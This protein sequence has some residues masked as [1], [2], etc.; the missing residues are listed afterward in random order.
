MKVGVAK[1]SAPGETRVAVV[2]DTARRLVGDGV[3]VLVERG[4]G[5]TAT[6][7]DAAYEQAG[8]A[9]C[10]TSSTPRRTSPAGAQ[11]VPDEVGAE[12]GQVLL[13][14]AAGRR[15]V[16][17]LAAERGAAL[18]DSIRR[19]TRAKPMDALVPEHG[20]RLHGGRPRGVPGSS[21]GCS[22]PRGHDPA[23]SPVLAPGSQACRRSPRRGA[24]RVV[25]AFDV[26][27]PKEQVESWRDLPSS[28]SR[29]RRESA[30]PSRRR[31]QHEREQQLI[32]H[33]GRVRRGDH[34]GAD[35][36]PPALELITERGARDARGWSSS[37]AAEAR[38]LPQSRARL[39]RHGV[40]LAGSPT[41]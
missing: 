4:A 31:D 27:R 28:T 10:P 6:F 15:G 26:R 33:R 13:L 9:P 18:L 8:G 30:A 35:P 39:R 23:G 24:R 36:G 17:R 34:Y 2:P 12:E 11:F 40:T 14:A 22:P 41:S 19:V 25:S 21:S 32:A 1:E 16:A 37:T 7:A 3:D 5:E 29:A 38:Q 20:R